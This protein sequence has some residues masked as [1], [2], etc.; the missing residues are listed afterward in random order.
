MMRSADAQAACWRESPC[1][2]HWCRRACKPA[3]PAR[4]G[5]S[6]IE[7][8]SGRRQSAR[9]VAIAQVTAPRVNSPNTPSGHRFRRLFGNLLHR[10]PAPVPRRIGPGGRGE[11]SAAPC[12]V[13]YH[14][15]VDI[16]WPGVALPMPKLTAAARGAPRARAPS[17]AVELGANCGQ[18]R[19]AACA[20]RNRMTRKAG[21]PS[22]PIDPSGVGYSGGNRAPGPR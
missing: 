8:S 5:R 17:I 4:R 10:H 1:G 12:L 22:G 11:A 19:I 15:H 20:L 6:R 16:R 7:G 3:F 9:G 13:P 18:P 2:R 21:E 14:Y